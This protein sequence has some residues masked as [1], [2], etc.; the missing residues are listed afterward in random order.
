MWQH[1]VAV[2]VHGLPDFSCSYITEVFF[3]LLIL[4]P[5]TICP[6]FHASPAPGCRLDLAWPPGSIPHLARDL[7]LSVSLGIK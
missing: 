5:G 2:P 1:S 6:A 7:E 3:P 4:D